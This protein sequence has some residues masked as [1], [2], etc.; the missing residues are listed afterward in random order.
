METKVSNQKIKDQEKKLAQFLQ[1]F[2]AQH[3]SRRTALQYS[4]R[5]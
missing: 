3:N 4:Q 1:P 2:F 5:L